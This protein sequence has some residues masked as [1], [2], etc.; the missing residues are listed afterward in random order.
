[1]VLSA[2]DKASRVN[3]CKRFKKKWKCY[4]KAT[5][6]A[7]A[8][9]VKFYAPTKK[10]DSDYIVRATTHGTLSSTGARPAREG[11]KLK[12]TIPRLQCYVLTWLTPSGQCKIK[13]IKYEGRWNSANYTKNV[14]PHIPARLRSNACLMEDNEK[15][16]CLP[17]RSSGP[18]PQ[19][20]ASV[21]AVVFLLRTAAPGPRPRTH[22][23]ARPKTDTTDPPL[24]SSDG[25]KKAIRHVLWDIACSFTRSFAARRSLF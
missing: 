2:A 17:A 9:P 11:A 13:C 6:Y 14:L 21:P 22:H 3:W 8:D 25:Q 16:G 1:M 5:G 24:P 18:G 7:W 23:P 19:T 15:V 12:K 4:S 10:T 20:R